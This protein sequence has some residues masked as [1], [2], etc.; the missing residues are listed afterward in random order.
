[1]ETVEGIVLSGVDGTN[2]LGFLTAV[3]ALRVTTNAESDPDI[4]V[5]MRWEPSNATWSPRLIGGPTDAEALA[6]SIIAYVKQMDNTVWNLDKR[7]PFEQKK[8]HLAAGEQ[9]HRAQQTHRYTIDVLSGLGTDSPDKGPEDSFRDTALRMVRSGDSNGQGFLH[10]ARSIREET[11]LKDLYEALFS[12]WVPTSARYSLRWEPL[13][14]REYA[15]GARNPGKESVMAVQG[16]NFLALE[17][18]PLFPV[19]PT[20]RT[21]RTTGFGDRTNGR[22]RRLVWPIWTEYLTLDAVRSLVTCRAVQADR[23]S[24][25]ELLELGIE[26]VFESRQYKPIQ[27]YSNFAP[28]VRVA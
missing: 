12:H 21:A 7:L 11:N 27:Y 3:G 26:A 22:E 16:A 24:K 28:A 23:R 25:P 9:V 5:R 13:E 2:P 1:M 19:V 20:G 6:R 14:A 8:F 17:A 15:L 10:Y 4:P 18:L